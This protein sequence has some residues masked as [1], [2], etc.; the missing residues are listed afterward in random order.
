MTLGSPTRFL[1]YDSRWKTEL[2]GK[3]VAPKDAGWTADV[4]VE[5]FVVNVAEAA[6][7]D[8]SGL[9][10]PLLKR[11]QS[12]ACSIAVFGLPAVQATINFKWK[13]FARRILMWELV[14]FMIWMAAFFG[15]TFLFQDED[16]TLSLSGLLATPRGLTTVVLEMVAVVAMVP[17]LMLEPGQIAAYG[18]SGWF[19]VWNGLDIITYIIQMAVTFMHLGRIGLKTDI[20]SILLS[21]QCIFILFR[22]QYFSRVFK[23]TRFSFLETIRDVIYEIRHYF[24][25]MMVLICGFAFSFHILF[26]RDQAV[27][28]FDTLPHSFLKV[29]FSTSNGLDYGEMLDSHV[30][31]F[32][33]LLNIFFQF[34]M[35][36]VMLNLLI[37][38]MSNALNRVTEH[39]ALKLLLH[40][41]TLIDELESTCPKYIEDVFEKWGWYPRHVHVLKIDQNSIERVNLQAL[42]DAQLDDDTTNDGASLVQPIKSKTA[43]AAAAESVAVKGEEEKDEEKV[44]LYEKLNS[45]QMTLDALTAYIKKQASGGGEGAAAA[46]G[47]PALTSTPSKFWKKGGK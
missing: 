11:W 31:V 7:P 21:L 12:G 9:I 47:G 18:L 40:K 37:G 8:A 1:D 45:I 26:R 27:G 46:A 30:P 16:L 23:T 13:T 14:V 19:S 44:A 33:A 3:A 6:D 41:A 28:N 17:F 35:G 2:R 43:T 38:V 5:A 20:L 10:Q 36:M 25:F 42:W 4:V 22:M 39:E 32:A 24:L 29:Y 34:S 15:F